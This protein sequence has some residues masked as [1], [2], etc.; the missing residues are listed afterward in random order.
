MQDVQLAKIGGKGVF[1]KEIEDALLRGDVRMA[2]HSMKDVPA[3]IPEGLHIGIVPERED[4]RD[5]LIAKDNRRLEELPKGARV[6]TGSLRRG[7]QL[8]HHRHDVEVVSIRGTSTRG[9]GK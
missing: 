5:V 2:V 4:P 3:E 8:R 1:V 9:S 7:M 6:G